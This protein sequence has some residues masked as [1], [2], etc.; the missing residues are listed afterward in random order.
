MYNLKL[1]NSF[2]KDLKFIKKRNKD[3]AKLNIVVRKL[4]NKETL[5]SKYR[6]HQL[7]N[8]GIHKNTRECHIEP[9]WLLIYCIDDENLIL[10]LIRTGSHSDL[11]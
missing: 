11:F 1:S 6:D 7:I 5:E 4:V 2:K 10:L 8:Y 3:V 9:D